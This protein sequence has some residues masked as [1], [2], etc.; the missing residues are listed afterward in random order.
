M[1]SKPNDSPLEAAEQQVFV[2]WAE[3]HH[4][5]LTAVPNSTYTSSWSQKRKN[6]VQGLRKGFPDIM[7]LIDPDQSKDRLG[8]FLCIEMKRAKGG[9]LSPEQRDWQDAINRLSTP[10]VQA[11]VCRGA[12]EAIK[13]VSHYLSDTSVIPF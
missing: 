3:L 13:V 9:T 7:V 1:S 5:K 4:L 10:H 12:A 11:Y 8:Y 2:E 6:H